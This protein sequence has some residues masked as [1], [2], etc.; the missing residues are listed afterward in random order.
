MHQRFFKMEEV[1]WFNDVLSGQR[2]FTSKS[3]LRSASDGKKWKLAQ[4]KA[5]T[6]K[7]FFHAVAEDEDDDSLWL[8]SATKQKTPKPFELRTLED[9]ISVILGPSQRVADEA[10]AELDDFLMHWFARYWAA[11]GLNA[12]MP[13]DGIELLLTNMKEDHKKISQLVGF[14]SRE[15]APELKRRIHI[16]VDKFSEFHPS[17]W[18]SLSA[19]QKT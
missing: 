4:Q 15:G 14:F 10:L 18:T 9:F 11:G 5:Q 19:L 12:E 3:P 13:H 16:F 17:C 6:L 7:E 1:A 8:E 2:V